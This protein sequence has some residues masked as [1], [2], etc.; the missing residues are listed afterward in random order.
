MVGLTPVITGNHQVETQSRAQGGAA[1]GVSWNPPLSRRKGRKRGSVTG[2]PGGVAGWLAR[3][4]YSARVRTKHSSGSTR[5]GDR[6]T[7]GARLSRLVLV[8][9]SATHRLGTAYP[10][11]HR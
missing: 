1:E 8:P 2:L 9:R 3:D 5:L 4:I 11:G 6:N 10:V 7:G